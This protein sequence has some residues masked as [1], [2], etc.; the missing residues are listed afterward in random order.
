MFVWSGSVIW[1]CVVSSTNLSFNTPII[2]NNST[3]PS[4]LNSSFSYSNHSRQS[5]YDYYHSRESSIDSSGALPKRY[6]SSKL[7]FSSSVDMGYHTL[8]LNDENSSLLSPFPPSGPRPRPPPPPPK[9]WEPALW[10]EISFTEGNVNVDAALISL[11]RQQL[12]AYVRTASIVGCHRLSD[13]GVR[14]L[15]S[16][17]PE[18]R[19]VEFKNCKNITNESIQDLMTRCA[20]IDHLDLS[21]SS[22]ISTV[23]IKSLGPPRSTAALIGVPSSQT[24]YLRY[25]DLSDCTRLTDTGLDNVVRN[26]PHLQFLYLRRCLNLT[27]VGIKYIATFCLGLKE[28]SLCDVSAITDFGLYELSK[29]GPS[30]RYLSIAKCERITDSGVS[31]ITRLCYKLR[32]LN[33]R[34]RLRSLDLG[35]CDITDE[36]LRNLAEKS[37]KLRKLSL[38]SCEMISDVGIRELAFKCRDLRHLN[39]Q[40]CGGISIEGYH[41]IKKVLQKVCH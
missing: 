8:S 11:L 10:R 25:L 9:L 27:D 2:S 24:L 12:D 1:F 31:Q 23:N 21:G 6:P 7:S 30:L 15:A 20:S 39:I 32:Y 22:L 35:K 40:D 36:G 19:K 4:S 3:N 38:K 14:T 33:I 5:S 29:L 16:R 17:C 26:A 34:T 13:T 37:C 18:L 28:L 41:A